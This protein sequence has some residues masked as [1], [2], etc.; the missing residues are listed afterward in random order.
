MIRLTATGLTKRYGATRALDQLDLDLVSGEIVGVAGPNGAG[1]ST[2]MRMLSGEET[3][4]S[5]EII[6]TRPN[7]PVDEVWRRVAI[8]HQEPHVWLNMTVEEN[9]AVGREGR[10]FGKMRPDQSRAQAVLEQLGIAAYSDH[11]LAN[12]SLAVQQRVEIARAMMRD[13]DIYLFD[14][15]NS[16]L[17]EQE[18]EALFATMAD[19][20]AS[21]KI[22]LLITHRLSDFV[23]CCKRVLILRDGRIGGE[24]VG[25]KVQETAIA[26]ELTMHGPEQA[27][28]ET[29]VARRGQRTHN[30]A[31]VLE[32]QGC[33]DRQ[34]LFREISL[35]LV[36]GRIIAL[37]GVEGSGA[38]ELA[39]AIGGFRVMME[40]SGRRVM[41][42]LGCLSRGKPARD[43]LQQHERWRKSGCQ[44][45][46]RGAE[47]FFLSARPRQD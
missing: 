42:E 43:C 30:T 44:T 11:E 2:L 35:S 32:L 34:D 22:I 8:V 14:E 7:E 31:P 3:A 13:A 41:V 9:L 1:K 17:T 38:R 15:P 18:S 6:L 16:A 20:A 26:A 37:A 4:D 47:R 36:P 39:Q 33:S 23:R 40:A 46:Q 19:L 29:R 28:D 5:G 27:A 24:L 25:A 21:Q 12:L 45:W 10:R